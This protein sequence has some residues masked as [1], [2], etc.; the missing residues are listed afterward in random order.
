[1]LVDM[2]GIGKSPY[3]GSMP[4]ATTRMVEESFVA[5]PHLLQDGSLWKGSNRVSQICTR[6]RNLEIQAFG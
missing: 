5:E 4:I 1:M 6:L 2:R 3:A